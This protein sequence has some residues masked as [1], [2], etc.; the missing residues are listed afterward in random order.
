M[1]GIRIS[2]WSPDMPLAIPESLLARSS[3]AW[4]FVRYLLSNRVEDE[5]Q[6][7]VHR[8]PELTG[9]VDFLNSKSSSDGEWANLLRICEYIRLLNFKIKKST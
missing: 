8:S 6:Q 4:A 3:S 5:T 7:P 9:H 2:R 1:L